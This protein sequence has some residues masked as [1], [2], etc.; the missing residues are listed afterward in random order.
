MKGSPNRL[1]DTARVVISQQVVNPVGSKENTDEGPEK[2]NPPMDLGTSSSIT[3]DQNVVNP[4]GNHMN[5]EKGQYS[6]CQVP[7]PMR[8]IPS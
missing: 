8:P 7:L 5:T 1:D 4:V 6:A 3:L 2:W